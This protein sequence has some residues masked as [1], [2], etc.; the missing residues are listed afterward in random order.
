VDPHRLTERWVE[1]LEHRHLADLTFSELRRALQ[2]LSSLYVE[3]RGAGLGPA[4][5][6][7][8]PGKRAAF[9]LFFGPLH[10]LLIG[11]VVR[12]LVADSPPP[13]SILDLGC[14]TGAA[15]AAWSL[16]AGGTPVVRGVDSNPWA[17]RETRR[18]LRLLGLRGTA[19]RGDLDQVALPRR[20]AGIVAAFVVNELDPDRRD[21]LRKRL[22]SSGRSGARILVVEPIAGRIVPWWR[23]WRERF[24]EAGGRSDTWRFRLPLPEVVRRLDRAAGLDHSELTGRSLF[25]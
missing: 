16:E 13:G 10:F 6:L 22:L 14:G 3:R 12:S 19:R 17:V 2:A 7:D 1:T 8:S 9:A 21:R 15:A 4:A 20:N 24:L 18:T 11:A 5:A 23:E 25:L